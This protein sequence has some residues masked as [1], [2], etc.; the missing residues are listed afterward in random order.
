MVTYFHQ[1]ML[2]GASVLHMV[3]INCIRR[4]ATWKKVD[5]NK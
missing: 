3:H 5:G 4:D 1:H 2:G